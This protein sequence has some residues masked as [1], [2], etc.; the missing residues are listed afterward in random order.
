VL[1]VAIHYSTLQHTAEPIL[2]SCV[3]CLGVLECVGVCWSVLGGVGVCREAL[4]SI[5]VWW[6][7]VVCVEVC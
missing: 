3:G 7:F 5:D 6:C 1:V 2:A 4:G